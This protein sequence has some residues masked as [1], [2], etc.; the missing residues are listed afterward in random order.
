M[1]I[2]PTAII[3]LSAK[4]DRTNPSGIHIGSRTYI[5]F[6]AAILAHDMCRSLRKDTWIGSD[7]FVGARAVILPGVSVSSG[8]IVAAGAVVTKN[9]PAGSIVA[10]NPARVIR[11]GIMVG[12]FGIMAA[13]PPNAHERPDRVGQGESSPDSASKAACLEATIG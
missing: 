5:A 12:P 6:G 3:S 11:S 7:C 8:S 10:G 9:V 2:C 4:L 13:E 1:D